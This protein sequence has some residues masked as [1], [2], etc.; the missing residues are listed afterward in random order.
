MKRRMLCANILFRLWK[1]RSKGVRRFLVCRASGSFS[2]SKVMWVS[3]TL[4]AA[5]LQPLGLEIEHATSPSQDGG[6]FQ[7]AVGHGAAHVKSA[8]VVDPKCLKLR[9]APTRIL[10]FH[11]YPN[12]QGCSNLPRTK[13]TGILRLFPVCRS[14]FIE[15]T[16]TSQRQF[17]LTVCT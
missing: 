8:R 2:W 9:N 14:Q 12:E 11:T 4:P 1:G 5:S 17:Y 3:V 6:R 15:G 7:T 13:W 16:R 10:L